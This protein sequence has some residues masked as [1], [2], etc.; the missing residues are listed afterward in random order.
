MFLQ[1][2]STREFHSLQ[3]RFELG[4]TKLQ[5][6]DTLD[7]PGYA[8]L[9]MILMEMK[10]DLVANP[11]TYTDIAKT[12][13]EKIGFALNPSMVGNVCK[14]LE[15]P[16]AFGAGPKEPASRDERIASFHWFVGWRLCGLR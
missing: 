1:K 4:D 7:A 6:L 10:P 3:A 14:E 5:R 9:A 2:D 15:I 16:T 13:G 11:K 8:K 12:V